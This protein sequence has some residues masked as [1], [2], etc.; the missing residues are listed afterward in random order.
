MS[1][2]ASVITECVTTLMAGSFSL[3][4][5]VCVFFDPETH[6]LALTRA[7][8][9]IPVKPYNYRRLRRFCELSLL[10]VR[11]ATGITQWRLAAIELGKSVPNCVERALIEN[12]LDQRLR[13]LLDARD[14]P[15]PLYMIARK[16]MEFR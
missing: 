9:T 12:F 6:L 2:L 15:K 1:R 11:L 13:T 7:A 16:R 3:S 4:T 14:D 8:K 5:I 10:D